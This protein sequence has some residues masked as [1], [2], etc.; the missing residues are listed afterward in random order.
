MKKFSSEELAQIERDIQYHKLAAQID[1]MR[2][3]RERSSWT[4]AEESDFDSAQKSSM[5][6]LAEL[7]RVR[8]KLREE[9][10][11]RREARY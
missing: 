9:L 4:T 11:S 10:G 6:Q 7:I 1:L 2:A 8:D 3:G 5:Y